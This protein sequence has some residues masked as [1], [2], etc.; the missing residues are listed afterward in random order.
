MILIVFV[1]LLMSFSIVEEEK[2]KYPWGHW[3]ALSGIF[4]AIKVAVEVA[5]C[6]D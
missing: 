4:V 1:A 5:M 3:L 2:D 6:Q